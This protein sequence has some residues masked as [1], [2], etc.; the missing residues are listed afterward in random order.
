MSRLGPHY[1]ETFEK[2]VFRGARKITVIPYFLHQ[3]LHIR[4]DIPEMMQACSKRFPNVRVVLGNTLGYDDA[5]ADLVQ[6]RIE[7]AKD[8]G[9]VR[10]MTLPPR[11]AFPVPPGQ[12]EFVGMPPEQ[13]ERWH[14]ENHDHGG[15]HHD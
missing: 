13:A 12:H 1:E 4:L 2:C 11:E 10:E 14:Q 9:D 6:R 15:H 7:E 8:L 3:G 5:I